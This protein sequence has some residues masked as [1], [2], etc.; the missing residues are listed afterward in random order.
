MTLRDHQRKKERRRRRESP[1][2]SRGRPCAKHK[3][4]P[5]RMSIRKTSSA[6]AAAATAELETRLL[7]LF[8]FCFLKDKASFF[9]PSPPL[10]FVHDKVTDHLIKLN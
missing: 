3:T 7:I 10:S 2:S 8:F 5:K 6:E 1:G 9:S 4:T